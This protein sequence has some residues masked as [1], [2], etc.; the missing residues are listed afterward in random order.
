MNAPTHKSIK[1]SVIPELVKLI[2][3]IPHGEQQVLLRELE[4]RFANLNRNHIRKE[5]CTEVECLT[6]YQSTKGHI[7]NISAGGVFIE[8]RMPFRCGDEI[9]LRFVFPQNLQKQLQLTG[10]IVRI[11]P[12]G[13]GVQFNRISKENEIFLTSHCSNLNG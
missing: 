4:D 9:K 2:E 3:K 13:V 8:S 7:T 5:V 12:I 1:P 11:S 6:H 10:Q